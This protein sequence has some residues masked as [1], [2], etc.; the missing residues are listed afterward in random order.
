MKADAA[1][2]LFES[3]YSIACRQFVEGKLDTISK[4][5]EDNTKETEEL[6]KKIGVI[7][8]QYRDV[9]KNSAFEAI[10]NLLR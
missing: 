9:D 6:C 3:L 2:R 5:I 1:R 4:L 7:M 10:R 8:P